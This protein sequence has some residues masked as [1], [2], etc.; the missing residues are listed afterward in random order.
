MA[1]GQIFDIQ[2]FSIHDGPG[3]RTTAF[4]KGCPLRCLWCGNPESI[5]REPILSYVA[6][7]CIACGECV[8]SCP[9]AALSTGAE[10]TAIVD[11]RR[12]TNCGTCA[13]TCDAKALE[14]VG[15]EVSASH[16]L[17]VVLRDADYYE[18]SGGGMTL[19]GGEPLFQPDFAEALLKE[20]KY[21]GLHCCV[22]TSGYALWGVLRDLLPLVDLW[23]YD[24]KETDPALHEKFT[25]KP[26]TPVLDNLER[27]HD[28]GAE[29]LLRCPM[30]PGH[31][32]RKEHLDGIVALARRLPKIQGVE[33]LPYYDLWRAKLKRFG[34]ESALPESVKPPHPKTVDSWE[35][36]LRRRGVRLA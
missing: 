10:G 18:A 36:Y 3:I 7:K 21:R 34:L 20:A 23:L 2:R 13:P 29:I 5:S 12:C 26:N 8:T 4:L 33:L 11:R 15:R 16:V 35:A 9:E 28:A 32:A 6:D 22:E 25:G 19:S 1:D 14:I 24:F 17:D 31:N 30:I 27:L